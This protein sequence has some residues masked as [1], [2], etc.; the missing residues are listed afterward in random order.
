[1]LSSIISSLLM[2]GGSFLE[3]SKDTQAMVMLIGAV[4]SDRQMTVTACEL[5]FQA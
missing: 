1:M 2:T 3:K 5:A 4:H